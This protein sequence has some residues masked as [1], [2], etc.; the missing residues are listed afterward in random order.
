MVGGHEILKEGAI[1]LKAAFHAAFPQDSWTGRLRPGPGHT[2]S[3]SP[4]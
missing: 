2:G 1:V 4:F 3:Q